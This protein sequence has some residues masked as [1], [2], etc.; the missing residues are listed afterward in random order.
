MKYKSPYRTAI[1]LQQKLLLEKEREIAVFRA[2]K[3]KLEQRLA[4]VQKRENDFYEVL[5]QEMEFDIHQLKM[6][7]DTRGRNALLMM[8]KE[9][10]EMIHTLNVQYLSIKNKL[11]NIQELD[12][13][14][15][16][17]F[18]KEMLKKES[19]KIESIMLIK[20]AKGDDDL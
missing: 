8:I 5:L 20:K 14:K 7:V 4:Q 9:A 18:N 15:E 13:E 2:E 6:R 16:K 3:N 12:I 1:L 10:E 17:L 19:K 11:D